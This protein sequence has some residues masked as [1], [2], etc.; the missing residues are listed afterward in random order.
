MVLILHARDDFSGE[1]AAE[2]AL[3]IVGDRGGHRAARDDRR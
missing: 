3:V 1:Q 2:A